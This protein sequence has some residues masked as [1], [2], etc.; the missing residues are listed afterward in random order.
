MSNPSV[1]AAVDDALAGVHA[2]VHGEEATE[3]CHRPL[4]DR[5]PGAH[6]HHSGHEKRPTPVRDRRRLHS[7][8]QP[9]SSEQPGID[10]E[11]HHDQA[12]M[13]PPAGSGSV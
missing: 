13:G 6:E 1:G 11:G 10:R 2:D 8:R 12:A 7:V 5:D 3:Q 9:E 4:P